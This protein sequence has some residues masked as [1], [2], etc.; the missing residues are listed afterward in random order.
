MANPKVERQPERK[1]ADSAESKKAKQEAKEQKANTEQ[2]RS[3]VEGA[4]QHPHAKEADAAKA[5]ARAKKEEDEK[6]EAAVLQAELARIRIFKLLGIDPGE[7]T[8]PGLKAKVE[9]V[10]E[11][12]AS[13][14][15]PTKEELAKTVA[16]LKPAEDA[17][18]EAKEQAAILEEVVTEKALQ[19]N[20][21][22]EVLQA[23]VVQAQSEVPHTEANGEKVTQAVD[24]D[25]EQQGEVVQ[26]PINEHKKQQSA[27]RDSSLIASER[28][29]VA[30]EA[31][32][33]IITGDVSEEVVEAIIQE[34]IDHPMDIQEAADRISSNIPLL[35]DGEAKTNAENLVKRLNGEE[36]FRPLDELQPETVAQISEQ[37]IPSSGE[38][39]TEPQVEVFAAA[40]N[41]LVS[42]LH[43]KGETTETIIDAVGGAQSTVGE[44]AGTLEEGIKATR[45][46]AEVLAKVDPRMEAAFNTPRETD[47]RN[48][49]VA[50]VLEVDRDQL[51][52]E[53]R[54]ALDEAVDDAHK[55]GGERGA[56]YTRYTFQ[57]TLKKAKRLQKAVANA[58]GFEQINEVT[59]QEI[60]ETD[61]TDK[62][63]PEEK[64]SVREQV[65]GKIRTII[66]KG[67]VGNPVEPATRPSPQEQRQRENVEIIISRNGL[68]LASRSLLHLVDDITVEDLVDAKGRRFE[69]PLTLANIIAIKLNKK[70]RNPQYLES[71]SQ[72]EILEEQ[73]SSNQLIR[74]FKES[75][76]SQRVSNAEDPDER[77]QQN[78][79]F[80]QEYLAQVNRNV[81]L[82]GTYVRMLDIFH[83]RG[84]HIA[85]RMQL[86]E[87]ETEYQ[88]L[89][90]DENLETK[91]KA[92][93]ELADKVKDHFVEAETEKVD[94][95][96]ECAE[97]VV[98]LIYQSERDKFG[99]GGEFALMDRAI[100]LDEDGNEHE[101]LKINEAHLMAWVRERELYFDELNPDNPQNFEQDIYIPLLW[102]TLT[103][104]ELLNTPKY[105]RK[106][107]PAAS[108]MASS[109]RGHVQLEIDP[110]TKEKRF[111]AIKDNMKV[112]MSSYLTR[113]VEGS[114]EI[115][116]NIVKWTREGRTLEELR[117]LGFGRDMK[118]VIEDNNYKHDERYERLRNS[119]VYEVWFMTFFH[120]N[121][122]GY[123]LANGSLETLKEFLQKAY[124]FNT[125]TATEDRLGRI[126][127]L[128]GIDD[129]DAVEE[130]LTKD[131]AS[132]WE[133]PGKVGR[134]FRR[135]LTAYRFLNDE[136]QLREVLKSH[137]TDEN[138][139]ERD[140]MEAFF[141]SAI[142]SV[143]AK[144]FIQLKAD[145]PEAEQKNLN[146]IFD[147]TTT[148][149]RSRLLHYMQKESGMRDM[150][151]LELET[152][153]ASSGDALRAWSIR[154]MKFRF[155]RKNNSQTWRDIANEAVSDADFK[156]FNFTLQQQVDPDRQTTTRQAIKAATRVAE[157]LQQDRSQRESYARDDLD[158][159]FGE[160]L[161]YRGISW[162]GITAYLDDGATAHDKWANLQATYDYRRGQDTKA[163][164]G[165]QKNMPGFKRLNL[166]P[167][168]VLKVRT[169]DQPAFDRTWEE[170]LMG[171]THIDATTRLEGEDSKRALRVN[172]DYDPR[173]KKAFDQRRAWEWYQENKNKV[174]RKGNPVEEPEK[175]R[176]L[177]EAYERDNA[178]TE[179][180]ENTRLRE[181][182]EQHMH[183]LRFIFQQN[184]MRAYVSNHFD[185]GKQFFEWLLKTPQGLD[186]LHYMRPNERTRVVEIDFEKLDALVRLGLYKNFRY[187]W[188]NNEILF[189]H[190]TR[191]YQHEFR[192]D[193]Q[194]RV[195]RDEH[196]HPIRDKV[197]ITNTLDRTTLGD[198]V[199]QMGG[200]TAENGMTI[201][202]NEHRQ[203]INVMAYLV[204]QWLKHRREYNTGEARI[205]YEDVQWVKAYFTRFVPS[206]NVVE[207]NEEGHEE[208][209]TLR[210]WFTNKFWENRIA[211]PVGAGS[212]R[213]L[214]EAVAYNQTEATFLGLFTM[215]KEF[216]KQVG[217]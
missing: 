81:R 198:E 168:Q 117:S 17:S 40:Q 82:L 47:V 18:N 137:I 84:H 126:M 107:T 49:L 15:E 108:A 85:T 30:V 6:L 23:A 4:Q 94:E 45:D 188:D 93:R 98:E 73:L 112:D 100:F 161:A 139:S 9:Q 50:E 1:S 196:G 171:L 164:G 36:G 125:L 8:D 106:R 146:S 75:G 90:A 127:K 135:V 116:I 70:E 152:M 102:R 101:Y 173:W 10:V 184:A 199:L 155:E 12:V 141:K 46:D 21:S 204:K 133:V 7:P 79:Q 105:F 136:V 122:A 33:T 96:L 76:Q 83:S 69:G 156:V 151:E 121:D 104:R 61:L 140:G 48:E 26:L 182:Y 148:D 41:V 167:M 191:T 38:E 132:E 158:L 29:E 71:L 162:L 159:R 55:I 209:E 144:A 119:L 208:V 63:K 216:I 113:S 187:I 103:L 20:I 160:T 91:L 67:L 138:G 32:P 180:A 192:R 212:L 213:L 124:W 128:A 185:H 210:S 95:R 153:I 183:N 172:I 51:K 16:H 205:G 13:E 163:S 195:I 170:M 143:F 174:D 165:A 68:Q 58:M 169:V 131:S 134:V 57:E 28:Q 149:L 193:A 74:I 189:N 60:S 166:L 177:R 3:Q 145:R 35:E 217:K 200:Y 154:A 190:N 114:D 44:K 54:E 181:R 120:D 89:I 97:D 11:V 27:D 186:I 179:T 214:L 111:F 129:A 115:Y 215:I 110:E 142:D 31:V 202:G 53:V 207:E 14:A 78:A 86:S 64:K 56:G 197:F 22:L 5:A 72:G 206:E 118:A 88:A 59:T 65:V 130:M 2:Q 99:E 77:A 194:G 157:G 66:E 80:E 150:S 109:W 176:K 211:G 175:N 25:P 34:A 19:Q 24:N 37:F 92:I 62:P 201:A 43:E 178:G 203:S 52:P 123:R 87:Y 147:C 39:L 42:A